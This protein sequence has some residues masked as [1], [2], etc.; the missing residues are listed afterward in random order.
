MAGAILRN[1]LAALFNLAIGAWNLADPVWSGL[2][3]FL[4]A[5]C[6]F[7]AGVSASLAFTLW[8][9]ERTFRRVLG[10]LA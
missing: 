2:S 1:I 6:M 5:L 7:T 4:G 3:V 10:R 8:L 9:E